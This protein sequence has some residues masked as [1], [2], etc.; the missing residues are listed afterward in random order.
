MHSEGS[1]PVAAL[2]LVA[3]VLLVPVV[4]FTLFKDG[5]FYPKLEIAAGN[6]VETTFLLN[7]RNTVSSCENVVRRVGDAVL[8]ACPTCRLTFSACLSALDPA[9]RRLLSAEP[10]NM[11]SSRLTD[12]VIIYRSNDKNLAL[13]ACQESER[14]SPSIARLACFEP[15]T[16]RPYSAAAVSFARW[17]VASATTHLG[18]AALACWLASMFIVRF[19]GLHG[20]WSMDATASGPQKFHAVATP[21]IGGLAILIGLL[22][23]GSGFVPN[24]ANF[25]LEEYGFLLL[26]ALPAFAAGL[27]ED[28]TKKV[29]VTTRLLSTIAA[30]AVCAWLLSAVLR[31][32]DLP[33]ADELLAW[34]PLAVAFTLFAVGGVANS[35]NI[36]DGYNG[37]AGGYAVIVLAAFGF[38]GWQVGD[39]LIIAGAITMM[40]A[41][42]GFLAWNYPA[43][44]IFLGDG[45]AYLVGFWIAELAVLLTSRNPAVSPWFPLLLLSYPVFETLFSIYRR[46]IVRG[47]HPGH[48]DALHMHQL[49]YMRLARVGVGAK[50]P[51]SITARN[52]RVAV[53]VWPAAALL[54]LP[55]V[56]WWDDTAMLMSCTIGFCC[57]YVWL[58]RQLVRWRAPRWM[59]TSHDR[60]S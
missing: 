2:V 28:I 7:G 59:I 47:H 4:T 22:L 21:R 27:A 46:Q 1:K 39:G 36:I 60:S 3:V 20:A 42:I 12:G 24:G 51:S 37:L 55:A 26:S 54:A 19:R 49:I 40:G 9:E 10:L 17:N 5:L 31:R 18:I 15:D 35:L 23:T 53:Y 30:A 44:R 48:P 6:Q 8:S 25:S 45:G 38:V 14:V 52:S 16:P 34:T 58:Y 33:F 50:D 11:P 29:G 57:A 13:Q 41:L 32:L 56:A 43:G